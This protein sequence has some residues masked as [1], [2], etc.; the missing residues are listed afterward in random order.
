VGFG[1]SEATKNELYS[2]KA[3]RE[4]KEKVILAGTCD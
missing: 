1:E 2:T 3:G 4:C